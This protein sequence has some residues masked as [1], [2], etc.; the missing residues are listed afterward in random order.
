M[1]KM[2][3]ILLETLEIFCQKIDWCYNNYDN[4]RRNAIVN[5][6]LESRKF[7]FFA[8]TE[9]FDTF[10]NS[11]NSLRGHVTTRCH[12]FNVAGLVEKTLA[13]FIIGEGGILPLCI[14]G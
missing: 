11:E 4:S 6:R 9:I 3:S 10:K 13:L 7:K 5:Q 1:T 14:T 12:G 8:F 2:N